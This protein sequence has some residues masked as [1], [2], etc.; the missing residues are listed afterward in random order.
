MRDEIISAVNAS[1]FMPNEPDW[2]DNNSSGSAGQDYVIRLG[3]QDIENYSITLTNINTTNGSYPGATSGTNNTLSF[4]DTL[5][6]DSSTTPDV[7]T[8]R[9]PTNTVISTLTTRSG[10]TIESIMD[11]I[12]AAIQADTNDG[13]GASHNTSDNTITLTATAQGRYPVEY[14][15]G[16]PADLVY[17]DYAVIKFDY[18]QGATVTQAGNVTDLN[19]S[20]TTQGSDEAV[21]LTIVDPSRDNATFNGPYEDTF[22][23]AGTTNEDIANS[24][25]ARMDLYWVNWT[26]TVSDTGVAASGTATGNQWKVNLT[27]T[28]SDW[29]LKDRTSTDITVNDIVYPDDRAVYVK[30]VEYGAG[31]SGSSSSAT[32]GTN[33]NADTNISGNFIPAEVQIGHPNVLGT[34]ITIS[35][36]YETSVVSQSIQLSSAAN[37]DNMATSI[38][39]LIDSAAVPAL[40]ASASGAVLTVTT[41][42][43]SQQINNITQII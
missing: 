32:A 28:A 10:E 18:V 37:P 15:N 27:S 19:A 14:G 17:T 13:W 26:T 33:F 39:N 31:V 16:A 20:I 43:L 8:M 5:N 25:K 24:I 40:A 3:T 4:S 12:S 34:T 22:E 6:N 2:Y 38:A 11:R 23:A 21:K 36:D 41:N 30:K 29:I 35:V 9:S 7:V 42:D 1:G